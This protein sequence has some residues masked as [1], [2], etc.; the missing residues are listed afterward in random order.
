MMEPIRQIDFADPAEGIAAFLTILIM[1]LAF[2]ITEGI[3][4][5]IVA[6][7]LLRAIQRRGR[8]SIPLLILS[9]LF[10]LRYLI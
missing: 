10:L 7:T 5:G 9:A 3:A 6:Y 4:V 8:V 1:P 2:S